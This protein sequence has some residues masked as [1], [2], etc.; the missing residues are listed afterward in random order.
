MKKMITF[1]AAF[2]LVLALAPTAQAA[3]VVLTSSTQLNLD[4]RDVLAAVNFYDPDRESARTVGSI[5][6]V[7]F[8]DFRINVDDTGLPIALSAGAAGATLS[9]VIWLTT[10]ILP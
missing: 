8:D 10:I 9:T 7:D 5:Q 4:G 2:A 1:L 3:T 6:G